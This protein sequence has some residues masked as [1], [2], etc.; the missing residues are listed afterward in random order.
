VGAAIS[1]SNSEGTY[2]GPPAFESITAFYQRYLDGAKYTSQKVNLATAFSIFSNKKKDLGRFDLS[3]G[4]VGKFN[5]STKQVWP[6]AGLSAV[7]GPL[8]LGYAFGEDESSYPEMIGF[9]NTTQTVQFNTQTLSAGIF[10]KSLALDYSQLNVYYTGAPQYQI[11]LIT[12]SLLLHR[13][14][15]TASKRVELSPRPGFDFTNRTLIFE[16]EKDDYFAGVQFAITGN[17][18]IATFYNYYLLHEFSLG[19]TWFL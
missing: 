15:I 14:I 7:V 10:F 19:L 11:N 2:F 17:V 5:T 16:N 9:E 6:G 13:W 12:A 3:L 8:T 18:Q 1:P 4:V